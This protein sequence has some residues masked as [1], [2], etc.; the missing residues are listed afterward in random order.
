MKPPLTSLVFSLLATTL[1]ASLHAQTIYDDFDDGD[2]DGSEW[3]FPE[4]LES[5]FTEAGSTYRRRATESGA[6]QHGVESVV[7]GRL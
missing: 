3:D 2:R 6:C 5:F 7:P 4:F 1:C